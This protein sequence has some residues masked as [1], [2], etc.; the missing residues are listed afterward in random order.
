M[1]LCT[2]Y[3]NNYLVRKSFI[4]AESRIMFY[5]MIA[6]GVT[7]KIGYYEN[8]VSPIIPRMSCKVVDQISST[9]IGFS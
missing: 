7:T 8:W 5:Y 9:K 6:T 1:V 2:R 3:Q 4:I